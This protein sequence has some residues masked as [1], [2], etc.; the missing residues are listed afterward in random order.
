MSG[1]VDE[2]TQP[3]VVRLGRGHW[4]GKFAGEFTPGFRKKS[5]AQAALPALRIRVIRK[6]HVKRSLEAQ[7]A[8]GDVTQQPGR[9][10]IT[11]DAGLV[12]A[13]DNPPE[14][15]TVVHDT[16]VIA[17]ITI[18]GLFMHDVDGDARS[19]SPSG[20]HPLS[21]GSGGDVG[22]AED[23]RAQDTPFNVSVNQGRPGL[24]PLVKRLRFN[25]G[26]E[27][28][29]SGLSN[30]GNT[31]WLNAALQFISSSV[32][33]QELCL[34]YFELEPASVCKDVMTELRVPSTWDGDF[35]A[36]EIF[37]RIVVCLTRTCE[38]VVALVDAMVLALQ[39]KF[40]SRLAKNDQHD[41]PEGLDALWD[42]LLEDKSAPRDI[43]NALKN[44]PVKYNFCR[45][46]D[47][48]G[49]WGIVTEVSSSLIMRTP[50]T[51]N[52]LND[53]LDDMF[54]PD[55]TDF[56][57]TCADAGRHAT[58]VYTQVEMTEGRV[59]VLQLKRFEFSMGKTRMLT[60]EIHIPM[61]L[62]LGAHCSHP[63]VVRLKA[64][65]VKRGLNANSGHF[66]CY[67]LRRVGHDKFR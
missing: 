7:F 50:V 39:T 60:D 62:D 64:V 13:A 19:E 45:K 1:E 23:M 40:L 66:V 59:V 22:R 5:D 63:V 38:N 49:A 56:K 21:T 58:L 3:K 28:Y 16:P 51:R 25:A 33:L 6:Q 46:C 37:S 65:V 54:S 36:W 12:H 55:T 52:D 11:G 31:C 14:V 26:R 41:V 53:C 47:K 9:L 15:V 2:D 44:M 27:I 43:H 61:E 48:P 57:C 35:G 67:A 29:A 30:V 17:G 8:S 10:G 18:S 42:I 20:A 32:A 34:N 24:R 4:A